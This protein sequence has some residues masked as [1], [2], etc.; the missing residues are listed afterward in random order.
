MDSDDYL[1]GRWTRLLDLFEAED[2]RRTI[3]S[4]DN[5]FHEVAPMV[6]GHILDSLHKNDPV[7]LRLPNGRAV[8][9]ILLFEPDQLSG[10]PTTRPVGDGFST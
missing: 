9:R 10:L 5:R 1:V 6:I 4:A 2:L 7:I 3:L 8:T